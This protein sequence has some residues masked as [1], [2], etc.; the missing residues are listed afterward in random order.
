M[1]NLEILVIDDDPE[2]QY[3][4]KKALNPLVLMDF[5]EDYEEGLKLYRKKNHQL[6][7]LDIHLADQNGLDNLEYA[8]K[9]WVFDSNKTIIITQNNDL[10]SEIRCHNLG[11]RDFIKKPFNLKLLR[12]VLDKH[13]VQISRGL[14]NVVK[15][16]PFILDLINYQVH[17]EGPEP[18][19]QERRD[20]GPIPKKREILLTQKE[21]ALLKIF[22][23][24]IGQIFPRQRLFDEV[25]KEGSRALLRNV[26]MHICSLKKKIAPY[27]YMIKNRR[28][29]GYFLDF[30]K[31]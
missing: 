13:L 26:D 27:G 28:S 22:L 3:F 11:L 9:S 8:G 15:E 12:V 7:L 31:E 30:E 21:F 6:V 19:A 24:H 14:K 2:I 23:L 4:I 16:G 29:I 1:R 25:W 10:E 18:E 20:L 17:L 5:V